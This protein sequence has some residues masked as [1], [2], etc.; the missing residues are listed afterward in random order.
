MRAR[1]KLYH[2]YFAVEVLELLLLDYHPSQGARGR[3]TARYT[4][5]ETHR[6]ESFECTCVSV[7]FFCH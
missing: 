5:Q 2:C 6:I 4:L 1:N 3:S 7:R